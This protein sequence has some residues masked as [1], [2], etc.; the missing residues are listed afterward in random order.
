MGFDDGFAMMQSRGRLAVEAVAGRPV[1]GGGRPPGPRMATADPGRLGGAEERRWPSGSW[2]VRT[3]TPGSP[4][5]RRSR[6]AA[7]ARRARLFV[8]CDTGPLHLA[9]AVGTPCVGLY[10]PWPAER[11]GPY[12]PQHVALQKMVCEGSTRARRNAS[13]KYIE[14]IGVDLVCR[15]CD[16]ILARDGRQAA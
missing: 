12:G 3:D 6:L 7:L 14:A 15:A 4:R 11:H 16:Q 9:A 5:R 2:P 13:P 10:G 1:R 8:G